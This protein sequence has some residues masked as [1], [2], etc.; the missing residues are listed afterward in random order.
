ML[1][2]TAG[3][4][5]FALTKEKEQLMTHHN[6]DPQNSPHSDPVRVQRAPKADLFDYICGDSSNPDHCRRFV[7]KLEAA[8]LNLTR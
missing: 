2:H 7:E 5:L 6:K 4:V 3:K 8:A 1:V